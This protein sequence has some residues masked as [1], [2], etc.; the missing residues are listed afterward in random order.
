M[1]VGYMYVRELFKEFSIS[2]TDGRLRS[3]D[4][5]R[6]DPHARMILP[7][8]NVFI[9]R[10]FTGTEWKFRPHTPTTII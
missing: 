6:P 4:A 8:I 5:I 10:F 2:R 7:P 9:S 1:L 3:R